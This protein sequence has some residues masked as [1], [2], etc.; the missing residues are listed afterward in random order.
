MATGTVA[1]ALFAASVVPASAEEATPS[2]QRKST[3]ALVPGTFA[4]STGWNGVFK[5]LKREGCPVIVAVNPLRGL[6][7][8]AAYLKGF[9]A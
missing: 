9:L 4:Y 8:D 3:V 7:R 6:S 1:A 5:E 2:Q